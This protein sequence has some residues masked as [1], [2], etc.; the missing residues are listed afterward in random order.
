[1]TLPLWAVIALAIK[2]DSPGPAIYTQERVGL[3]GNRFRFLKFRTMYRDADRIR[4]E[5][6]P[7]NEMDGPVFKIRNDP[8]ITRFGR[9]LRRSSLDEL[10]QLLNVLRGDMSLVGPRPPLP[11]EVANYRPADQLRLAVKPG[12]TCLWQIRG[13]SDCSFEQWMEYDREYI[14]RL[15]LILDLS[16]M[17]RTFWVVLHQR[18][19]Y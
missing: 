5:I 2:V 3:N 9:W 10:P 13:R 8:R 4:S 19:A 1:M 7:L 18:G 17:A 12:L 11:I 14:Q 15:S 16:I 6:A